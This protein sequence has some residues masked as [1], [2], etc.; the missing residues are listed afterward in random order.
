MKPVAIC[1]SWSLESAGAP[2]GAS[3]LMS[4]STAESRSLEE[5]PALEA[6]EESE[7]PDCRSLDSVLVETPSSEAVLVIAGGVGGVDEP[8]DG[9]VP[10]IALAAIWANC[11]SG[12]GGGVGREAVWVVGSSVELPVIALMDICPPD[13]SLPWFDPGDR[14]DWAQLA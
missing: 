9:A 5:T 4:C 10:C 14:P 12:G 11:P 3:A 1:D 8:E 2:L 13:S 7:S 6:S